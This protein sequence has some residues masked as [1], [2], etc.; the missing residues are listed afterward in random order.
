MDFTACF[1]QE[2]SRR[3]HLNNVLDSLEMLK[4]SSVRERYKNEM[5]MKQDVGA[6]R[7]RGVLHTQNDISFGTVSERSKTIWEIGS[8][9]LLGIVVPVMP[10]YG[11]R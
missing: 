1:H 4:L 7:K 8:L 10:Y 2:L 3:L 6:I 5:K 9:K 11:R